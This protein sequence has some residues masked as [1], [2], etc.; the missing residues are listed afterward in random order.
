MERSYRKLQKK[1]LR[2]IPK[3]MK[4]SVPIRGHA[5]CAVLMAWLRAE[6]GHNDTEGY[7]LML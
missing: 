6:A 2:V 1:G 5:T 7:I 3:R 4:Q